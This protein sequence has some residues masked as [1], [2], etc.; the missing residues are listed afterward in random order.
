[1]VSM[2]LPHRFLPKC[3]NEECKYGLFGKQIIPIVIQES[4]FCISQDSSKAFLN[5]WKFFPPCFLDGLGTKYSFKFRGRLLPYKQ[6][7]IFPV[8]KISMSLSFAPLV[9]TH[10]HNEK[11]NEAFLA[12]LTFS[13]TQAKFGKFR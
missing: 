8:L 13:R 11:I 1:M 3:V 4:V 10:T 6:K 2:T 7:S 9:H 12:L 5:S